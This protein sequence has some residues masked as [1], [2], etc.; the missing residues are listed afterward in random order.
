MALAVL[1]AR[2]AQCHALIKSA[3]TTDLRRLAENHA[4]AMIDEDARGDARAGV[5][6]DAGKEA[7]DIR[8]HAWDER[9][10]PTVQRVDKAVREHRVKAGI[11]QQ[12]FEPVDRSGVAFENGSP[13][14]LNL[15]EDG[16]AVHD[17]PA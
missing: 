7:H 6:L 13:V 4:H 14:G 12:Y 9:D 1:Q 15:P 5:N 10:S 8:E 16:F 3:V 2:A 11:C 17:G